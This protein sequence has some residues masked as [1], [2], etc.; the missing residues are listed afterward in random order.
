MAPT[1]T[2]SGLLIALLLAALLAAL[3]LA[4]SQRRDP[5]FGATPDCAKLSAA[6][7]R[8][9]PECQAPAPAVPRTG[10]GSCGAALRG[11]LLAY[12]LSGSTDDPAAE[13]ALSPNPPAALAALAPLSAAALASVDTVYSLSMRIRLRNTHANWR[14]LLY[15]GVADNV[16]GG[17]RSPGVWQTPGGTGVHF[18]HRSTKD[19][20]AGIDALPLPA[21]NTWYHVVV[22]VDG[23]AMRAYVDGVLK[24]TVALAA[25][26]RFKWGNTIAQKRLRM[27]I[28]ENGCAQ[29]SGAQVAD[30]YM[31]PSALAAPDVS[32]LFAALYGAATLSE[33][34]C[35]A[36]AARRLPTA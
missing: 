27:R 29:T 1:P 22:T 13:V 4:Q 18:R 30:L 24:Q 6:G 7:Q 34:D 3:A 35:A 32:A 2:S 11:R 23:A 20:N 8:L 19:G 10:G 5:F 21:L 17:D 25:G 9:V 36:L 14:N 28:A 15:Y 16:A 33:P 12:A 31:L 26:D